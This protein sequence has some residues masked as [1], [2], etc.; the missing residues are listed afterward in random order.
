MEVGI[1][2]KIEKVMDRYEEIVTAM[3]AEVKQGVRSKSQVA[4]FK[5]RLKPFIGQLDEVL[6]GTGKG[7]VPE[8]DTKVGIYKP[9]EIPPPKSTE[10]KGPLSWKKKKTA[11]QLSKFDR[12]HQREHSKIKELDTYHYEAEVDGAIV[13]YWAKDTDTYFA[14]QGRIEIEVPGTRQGDSARVFDTIGKLGISSQ[15]ATPLDIE[16]LY[17]D[18]I[19]YIHRINKKLANETKGVASQ[20]E[21]VDL[22]LKLLNKKLKTDL[23]QSPAYNPTGEYQAYGQ[24]WRVH[25]RPEL[26]LDPDFKKFEKER[27]IVHRNTSNRKL[28]TVV[29]D[30]LSSGGQMASTTD[31]V[32]RGLP[33]GGMSPE[34]DLRSGGANYFFARIRTKQSAYDEVG[35][36]W[37]SKQIARMDAISYDSDYYGRT[38]GSHV[39]NN[40]QVDLKDLRKMA[41]FGSNET[42]FKDSLSLFDDLDHIVTGNK[43]E[44]DA[45]IKVFRKAGYDQWPDGRNL[46]DVIKLKG[47][48]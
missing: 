2:N 22:K 4:D 15:R 19:G 33:P 7:E 35:F 8:W 17:L 41:Q 10:A 39:Q 30:V 24:G 34:S 43:D 29:K 48:P 14:L 21:R 16:E 45:I 23:K 12:G 44:R 32:R 37:K 42:I 13:R 3:Q 38:T 9:F 47:E 6:G 28:E 31:K 20:Q 27:R 5:K 36:V 46:E 26:I 11:Y 18:K 1:F 25:F 40:R